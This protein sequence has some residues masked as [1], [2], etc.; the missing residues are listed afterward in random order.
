MC[1][2]IDDQGYQ[3]HIMSAIGHQTKTCCYLH[4]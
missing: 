4:R 2:A 3:T 1:N